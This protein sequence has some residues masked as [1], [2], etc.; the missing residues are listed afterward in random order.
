VPGQAQTTF[1][2][3]NFNISDTASNWD[4]TF[5]AGI[6]AGDYN[7]VNVGPDGT[8][9]AVWTDARNG[10]SSR[11][12]AGRNPTCEQSDIFDDEYSSNSGATVR[13]SATQGMNL[14]LTTPCPAAMQDK[15]NRP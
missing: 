5:R 14:Y 11:A 2:F 8:A 6:F 7:N 10:R 1:P 13:N 4:Y 12:Q 3:R 9:W 15:A